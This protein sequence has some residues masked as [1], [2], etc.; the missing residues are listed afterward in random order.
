VHPRGRPPGSPRRGQSNGTDRSPSPPSRGLRARAVQGR[1]DRRRDPCSS[2][3]LRRGT[4]Y[5]GRA[6][7]RS[8]TRGDPGLRCGGKPNAVEQTHVE[9]EGPGRGSGDRHA[10]LPAGEAGPPI[11]LNVHER[12]EDG[13]GDRNRCSFAM[14]IGR[15][16]TMSFA[17]TTDLPATLIAAANNGPASSARVDGRTVPRL[18]GRDVIPTLE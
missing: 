15:S 13:R 7:D 1:P 8:R 12:E 4:R 17:T 18:V 2:S 10:P 11:A 9:Q 5:R 3:P 6:D 16:A 14:K